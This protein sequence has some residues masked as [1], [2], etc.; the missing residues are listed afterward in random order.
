M[1]KS[2]PHTFCSGSES[3]LSSRS[4]PGK[5]IASLVSAHFPQP[6]SLVCTVC[7][8]LIDLMSGRNWGMPVPLRSSKLMSGPPEQFS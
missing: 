5:S 6:F 2:V 3:P 8:S 7:A 4:R 1:L